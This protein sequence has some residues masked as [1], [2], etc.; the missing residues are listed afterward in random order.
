MDTDA[1]RKGYPPRL[2]LSPPT[3]SASITEGSSSGTPPL[4]RESSPSPSISPTPALFACP[5]L[6]RSFSANSCSDFSSSAST[7]SQPSVT[8]RSSSASAALRKRGYVR[9]QGVT[10]APSASNRESVLSLGSIAHLQ[11]YFAR[12]GLLDGKGGQLAKDER[13]KPGSG[14]SWRDVTPQVR[15]YSDGSSDMGDWTDPIAKGIEQTEEPV[16]LPPTVS[17]YSH[18]TPYIPPPPDPESLRN[19]LVSALADAKKALQQALAEASEQI[20]QVVDLEHESNLQTPILSGESSGWH[21]IQGLNIL[22]LVTL[23][24]HAAKI[25][26]TSHENPMRL[27][28]IKSERQIRNELLSVMDVL[29]RMASRNFAGGMRSD[30]AKVISDWVMGIEDFLEQ[31]RNLETQEAKQRAG[32]TWLENTWGGRSRERERAF[33]SSFVEMDELPEWTEIDP[34]NPQPTAFTEALRTG[35]SL[36]HLHNTLLKKSKR[37]F[38]EIKQFHT[39]LAKP[40]R[41]A[42][43]LRYWIK[44][45]ELRWETKL[46]VNVSGVVNGKIEAYSDFD[47]AI[48]QWS[49]AVR[50]ELTREWQEPDN[51]PSL[52]HAFSTN[53]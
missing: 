44:A 30:E 14:A 29:K 37:Q 52:P 16:M 33:L 35:L 31:E 43:N 47:I 17:T 49:Q 24:I 34:S 51:R 50:E 22:D 39:D 53:H 20:G 36:V 28:N 10:F 11:Y 19:D 12:T 32:W 2:A 5:P 38:G 7:I 23:A 25:Y 21:E 42:E 3:S 46:R 8:S 9:P 15:T 48:L 41:C 18:R 40:Y 45:A 1:R 26:Y 4:T 6:S 27:Y 13:G